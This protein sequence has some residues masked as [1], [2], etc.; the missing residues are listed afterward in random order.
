M[1][2]VFSKSVGLFFL[3]MIS[4]GELCAQHEL[5]DSLAPLPQNLMFSVSSG[6]S[7]MLESNV[8]GLNPYVYP[9]L[10]QDI[11]I[12][13]DV[14]WNRFLSFKLGYEWHQ[15]TLDYGLDLPEFDPVSNRKNNGASIHGLNFSVGQSQLFTA[16][17]ARAENNFSITPWIGIRAAY[18]QSPELSNNIET[19]K[20]VDTSFAGGDLVDYEL[21]GD[22]AVKRLFVHQT[23]LEQGLAINLVFSLAFEVRVLK[24][25][26][27]GLQPF[28]SQGFSPL[29]NH[30]VDYTLVPEQ[31][32]GSHALKTNGSHYG[33]LFSLNYT[34][35]EEKL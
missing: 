19:V 1:N 2:Q 24:R 15:I 30:K 12:K 25:F 22:T 20:G 10:S 7:Y 18:A 27:V 5:Q 9:Q 23:K 34:I 14:I 29:V 16:K 17:N 31:A 3:G 11:N 35:W 6:P 32:R 4:F 33:V 21:I 28:Y 26:Y 8:D 13:A